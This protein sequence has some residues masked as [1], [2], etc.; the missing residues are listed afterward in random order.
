MLREVRALHSLP[1]PSMFTTPNEA[2]QVFYDALRL[3]DVALMMSVWS[4]EEEIVCIHPGGLR[5]IGHS[6]MQSAWQHIFANGPLSVVPLRPTIISS[7]MTSVHVLLEQVTVSTP[8]GDRTAHCYATNVFQ[9]GR[10]GWRMVLHH[11]SHTPRDVG[12][13][14]LQD[15]P[16]ILH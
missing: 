1:V 15:H 11:A 6:A 12:L 10:T 16:S 3:A 14:D 7:L 4:D 2:E 5:T 9:K 13:F 8:E